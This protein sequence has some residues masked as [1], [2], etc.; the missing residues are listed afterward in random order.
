[1]ENDA[2]HEVPA[3]V[4]GEIPPVGCVEEHDVRVVAGSE[5]PQPPGPTEDICRVDS[6]GRKGLRGRKLELSRRERAH[7]R[8]ALAGGAARIEVRRELDEGAGFD[9]RPRRWNRPG[10]EKRAGWEE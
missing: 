8:E 9:E 3:E 5:A 6:A 1:M 4:V 7:E 10:E 2:G